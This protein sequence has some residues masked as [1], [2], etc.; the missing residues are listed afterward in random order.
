M[1]YSA[2][3]FP[4]SIIC[5]WYKQPVCY[6]ASP[7]KITDIKST[8]NERVPIPIKPICS[9]RRPFRWPYKTASQSFKSC[10]LHHFGF[11]P[12]K[13]PVPMRSSPKPLALSATAKLDHSSTWISST[14]WVVV[15]L[16]ESSRAQ[17]CSLI[18]VSHYFNKQYNA[19]LLLVVDS[20]RQCIKCIKIL[21]W[22]SYPKH[23]WLVACFWKV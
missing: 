7:S 14:P 3:I 16:S 22:S 17:N 12:V 10:N 6:P 11:H 18:I 19:L 2:V 9:K 1:Y 4:P 23:G 15:R 21:G 8:K 20:S 13:T 5:P